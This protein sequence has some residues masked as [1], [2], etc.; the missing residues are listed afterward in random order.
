MTLA[1]HFRAVQS[2]TPKA[3]RLAVRMLDGSVG[4]PFDW[5]LSLRLALVER[6]QHAA[7]FTTSD[8][9]ALDPP[10]RA[11]DADLPTDQAQRFIQAVRCDVTA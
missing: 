10:G 5:R 7:P 11:V 2:L 6:G 4:I 1:H 8:L 3:A 9:I